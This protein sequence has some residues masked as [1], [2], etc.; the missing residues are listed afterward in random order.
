MRREPGGPTHTNDGQFCGTVLVAAE[1]L[2]WWRT[3]AVRR[4]LCGLVGAEVF[5][6]W[7]TRP[8]MEGTEVI[9]H[10]LAAMYQAGDAGSAGWCGGI[11]RGLRGAPDSREAKRLEKQLAKLRRAR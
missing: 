5:D 10:L 8:D 11:D 2:P 1:G 3:N 7:E 6:M 9:A 4:R